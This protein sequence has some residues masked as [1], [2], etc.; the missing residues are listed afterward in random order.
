MCY[1]RAH[2]KSLSPP[3]RSLSPSSALVSVANLNESSTLWTLQ[4]I[5]HMHFDKESKQGNSDSNT[6]YPI[7]IETQTE[8]RNNQSDDYRWKGRKKSN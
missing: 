4:D 5:I 7:P 8:P 1:S 3:S 6:K 2:A